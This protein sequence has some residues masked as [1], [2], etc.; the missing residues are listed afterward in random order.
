MSLVF[1][2]QMLAYN[3][4]EYIGYSLE[5][6]VPEVDVVGVAYASEP[7]SAYNALAR[8]AFKRVDNTRAILEDLSTRHENILIIEGRWDCEEDMRNDTLDALRTRGV[9]VCFIV[10]ADEFYSPGILAKIRSLVVLLDRPGTVFWARYKNC[11]R[12]LNY[13]IDTPQLRLPIA[14]HLTSHTSFESLRIPS[15]EKRRL[16]PELYYWHVG[17]VLPDDR[18]WEKINTFGHA[19]EISHDWFRD[20]WLNWTPETRD[21]CRR[22]PARWPQAHKI[23]PK[24]LPPCLHNH[25]YFL[26]LYDDEF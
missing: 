23:D 15:G 2:A 21:L 16:P 13:V 4:E 5:S 1:G 14:V 18:M 19:H 12:R 25:P 26:S 17:Y 7:F 6:L 3:Q 22:D 24:S 11:Y 10:D 20:K 9:D 8:R